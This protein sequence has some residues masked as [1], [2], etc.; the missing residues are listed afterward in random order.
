MP[1]GR[2]AAVRSHRRSGPRR[3]GRT[4][5]YIAV[6]V[7]VALAAGA[8]V[9][10][11]QAYQKT[12]CTGQVTASIAAA[13]S[14]APLL[15]KIARNWAATKPD[16]DGTCAAVTIRAA[17]S[18]KVAAALQ[19]T[20]PASLGPQPDVWVP[21]SSAWFRSA[22]SGEA[23]AILPDL[24]PSVA[25]SPVVL[26]MPKVMAQTLGWPAKTLNWSDVLDK[27]ATKKG[28]WAGYNKNWG[29][30]KLGMSD[31][32]VSTPGL[33]ALSAIIDRD[34]DQDVS[35]QE[36]QGLFK[37]KTVLQVKATDTADIMNE[38]DQKG[39]QGGEAGLSYV[40]AFPAL[41]QEVIAHNEAHP[42]TPLV[43]IYPASNL[44]ADNPYLV[45]TNAP[46]VQGI[47]QAA[48]REFLR[49]IRTNGK[50]VFAD[51]GY[52]DTNRR[53]GNGFTENN[54]V[55]QELTGLPRGVLLTD[56]VNQTINTWTALTRVTNALIMLDV[57]G[58]MGAEVPGLGKTKLDLTKDAA[59]KA[60]DVFH[61]AGNAGLWS[62]SSNKSGN[63]SYIQNVPLGP[64]DDDLS[65]QTREQRIKAAIG[66]L[67]AGGN[68]GMYESILAA[69]KEVQSK[70]VADAT[71]MVVLLTDGANDDQEKNLNLEQLLAALGKGDPKR[72]VSVVTISL[73]QDANDRILQQISQATSAPPPYVSRGAYDITDVMQKAIFGSR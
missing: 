37:L 70:Y 48:A 49:Y 30:F 67:R 6:P 10:G 65:G 52:R 32:G 12:Q 41:E 27:A 38:F 23:E 15:E 3:G 50:T 17:E 5:F 61:G 46:W 18:N 63:K 71:N 64:L 55:E 22:Q 21:E 43:A 69:Y 68:T 51:A 59:Q 47:K 11:Y 24:Q 66:N 44:E 16:A 13:P 57:S 58:S 31:P 34:D 45:L 56:A 39:G 53:P 42:S 29:K 33:L 60:V 4:A 7:I 35:D 8:G 36:I 14:T 19:S 20:W 28:G 62:F 9:Y 26:A 72:P 25:R 54:G 2:S 40:S 73:G 1:N